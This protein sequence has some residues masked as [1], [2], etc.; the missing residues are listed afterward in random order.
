[1]YLQ[2][3]KSN[4]IKYMIDIAL[5]RD[6]LIYWWNMGEKQKDFEGT[7][8]EWFDKQKV[9]I[10]ELT[11]CLRFEVQFGSMSFIMYLNKDYEHSFNQ[12]IK[13]CLMYL[14]DKAMLIDG[15]NRQ[16]KINWR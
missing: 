10:N 5:K 4:Q 14:G 9:I 8:K 3:F 7:Y 16:Y 1:M 15:F 12:I 13:I 6:I 11:N 2:Y